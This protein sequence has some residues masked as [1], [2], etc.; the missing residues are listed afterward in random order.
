MLHKLRTYNLH[1][2][3]GSGYVHIPN[4]SMLPLEETALQQHKNIYTDLK[5]L[6]YDNHFCLEVARSSDT[7]FG[8]LSYN[9]DKIIIS[10]CSDTMCATLYSVDNYYMQ[11]NCNGECQGHTN[12]WVL[13]SDGYMELYDDEVTVTWSLDD[14]KVEYPIDDQLGS[15]KGH[16]ELTRDELVNYVLYRLG[17]S[18]KGLNELVALGDGLLVLDNSGVGSIP[19]RDVDP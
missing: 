12:P 18:L 5:N 4:P 14:Y 6:E 19:F 16:H 15:F 9:V 17:I 7:F 8:T 1:F 11:C 3:I 13:D 2:T 10:N